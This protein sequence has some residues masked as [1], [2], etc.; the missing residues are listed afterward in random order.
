MC[1]WN[2]F[3]AGDLFE[4]VHITNVLFILLFL[5]AFCWTIFNACLES[6]E[7]SFQNQE[8]PYGCCP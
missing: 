6:A 2:F 8:G 3:L 1:F 5:Q 7:S 4:W